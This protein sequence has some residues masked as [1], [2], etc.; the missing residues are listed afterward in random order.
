MITVTKFK[1]FD[2]LL[3]PQTIKYLSIL[4]CSN[5]WPGKEP[6]ILKFVITSINMFFEPPKNQKNQ[7]QRFFDFS[8]FLR[9]ETQSYF[10]NPI[11]T[12]H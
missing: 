12:Q 10:K 6:P 9:I 1:T 5:N 4:W 7:N 2:D 11:P 3:G 8:N